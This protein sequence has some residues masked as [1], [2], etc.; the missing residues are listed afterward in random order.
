MPASTVPALATGSPFAALTRPSSRCLPRLDRAQRARTGRARGVWW[1]SL[2]HHTTAS[3]VGAFSVAPGAYGALALQLSWIKNIEFAGEFFADSKGYYTAAG[4]ESVDL[5]SGPVDS[6]DALVA[7]GTVDVGT[8]L[9]ILSSR[10]QEPVARRQEPVQCDR[11]PCKATGTLRCDSKPSALRQQPGHA[12]APQRALRRFGD[13]RPDAAAPRSRPADPVRGEHDQGQPDQ[14]EADPATG[15]HGLAEVEHA[16]QEL[17]RRRQVLEQAE[18]AQRKP[19]GGGGEEQQRYDG[20]RPGS[21]QEQAV[22][23]AEVAEG[24]P[25]TESEEAR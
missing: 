9:T 3:A 6:A 7:A 12:A 22:G 4:F 13:Q 11:N 17:Q 5:V 19:G 24:Q 1:R 16:Q 10:R 14:A 18:G 25:A 15:R 8:A 2:R 21:D 23:P 20:D